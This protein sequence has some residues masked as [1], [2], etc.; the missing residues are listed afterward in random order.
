MAAILTHHLQQNCL[1][2]SPA[3]TIPCYLGYHQSCT[4]HQQCTHRYRAICTQ[5]T[6]FDH[7]LT[8]RQAN[9]CL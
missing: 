1:L 3:R 8:S 7:D 9:A 6:S 5:T 4:G 2:S